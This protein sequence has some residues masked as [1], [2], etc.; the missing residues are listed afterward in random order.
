MWGLLQ[1]QVAAAG[2]LPLIPVHKLRLLVG[3]EGKLP[4]LVTRQISTVV[5]EVFA[6]HKQTITKPPE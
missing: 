5:K 2:V 4:S 6:A 1:V 3:V